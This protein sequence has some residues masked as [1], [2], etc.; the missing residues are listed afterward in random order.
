MLILYFE[1]IPSIPLSLK[2]TSI[3]S[4]LIN[5][6]LNLNSYMVKLIKLWSNPSDQCVQVC[7]LVPSLHTMKKIGILH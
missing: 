3:K 7:T 2:N 5:E 4:S 6:K 1:Y